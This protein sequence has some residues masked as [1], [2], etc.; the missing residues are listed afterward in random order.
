V[1]SIEERRELPKGSE[2]HPPAVRLFDREA[3]VYGFSVFFNI[4]ITRLNLNDVRELT[5]IAHDVGIATDYH[6]NESPMIEQRDFKHQDGN[7]TFIRRDKWP[8]VDQTID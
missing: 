2:P 4:N 7:S 5:E 3:D 6:I 8:H 1:D